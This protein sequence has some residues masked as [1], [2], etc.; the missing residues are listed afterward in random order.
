MSQ[1]LDKEVARQFEILSFGCMEI[2]PVEEFKSMLKKSIET[3]TPLKIKLGIDPTSPDVHLGHMVA[4]RKMRAFQDLGHRGIVIIGDYTAQIGDPTGKNESRPALTIDDT[5]ANA[6]NY[7][8]QVYKVLDPDKTTIRYQS[9]WFADVSLADILR[10]AAQTTVAKLISH[11]TFKRR[12]DEGMSLGLHE[13][14]YPVLQ[15]MDSVFIEADI[16][17]GG[18]DQKFNVLMGRDY[19]K[20]AGQRPQVAMNLPLLLGTDGKEKMSKS[21]GNYIGVLDEP[22][23]K[24]GKVMSIPDELMENYAMYVADFTVSEAKAFIDDLKAERL[25]PNMAKKHLA[26]RV[27]AQYH[28]KDVGDQ[29]RIQ[30]EKVFARKQLPDDVEEFAFVRGESLMKAL[31]DAAVVASNSEFRRLIKQNSI[32]VVDPDEGKISDANLNL[33]NSYVGKVIKVG[34]RRFLKLV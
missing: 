29:M 3:Q 27:V 7:M 12:I 23:D 26:E 24:F 5:T 2:T 31:C 33:D 11:D 25:H 21:L 4:F 28:G 15:G 10:W 20:N 8:E 1:D 32:S 6:K 14:F 9:E 30:F 19:Q 16:E 22:F 34:K 13:F 17:L 18:M